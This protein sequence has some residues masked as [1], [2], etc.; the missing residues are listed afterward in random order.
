MLTLEERVQVVIE[1]MKYRIVEKGIG[2]FHRFVIQKRFLGFLWFVD[3]YRYEYAG[4]PGERFKVRNE[5][6][7]LRDAKNYING[8]R[9]YK[10]I[11]STKQV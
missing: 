4:R 5:F 2:H 11:I 10:R 8:K 7:M 6:V 9:E 1:E 3:E